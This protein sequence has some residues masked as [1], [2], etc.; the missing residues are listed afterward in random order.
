ML[1]AIP[2]CDKYICIDS[3]VGAG[4]VH[5]LG[6]RWRQAYVPPALSTGIFHVPG[7]GIMLWRMWYVSR[8]E[9]GGWDVSPWD[10][11]LVGML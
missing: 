1:L 11:Q 6:P 9:G 5:K 2:T 7:L 10:C 4:R 3:V 8:G